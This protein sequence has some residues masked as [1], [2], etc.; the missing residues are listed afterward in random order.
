[1]EHDSG[2][3]GSWLYKTRAGRLVVSLCAGAICLPI[4]LAQDWLAQAS[5]VVFW[6]GIGLRAIGWMAWWVALW[7]F[8]GAII[9]PRMEID[10]SADGEGD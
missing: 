2:F 9:G 7:Y 10:F 6:V 5:G 8:I 1:V 3:E 4:W